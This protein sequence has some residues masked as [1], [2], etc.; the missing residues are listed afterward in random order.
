[1]EERKKEV[2]AFAKK[3]IEEFDDWDVEDIRFSEMKEDC[4]TLGFSLIDGSLPEIKQIDEI[5]ELE[6]VIYT[7]CETC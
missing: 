3:W 6:A 2:I 1:M 5:E 7:Q 4:E